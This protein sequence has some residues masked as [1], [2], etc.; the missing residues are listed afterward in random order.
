MRP[1][2]SPSLY[3]PPVRI[4]VADN[5][6]AIENFTSA[7]TYPT[8]LVP[9]E[10]GPG[11]FAWLAKEQD[12][13]GLF[14]LIYRTENHVIPLAPETDSMTF[15]IFE[16]GTE[17][18]LGTH[19]IEGRGGLNSWYR[20]NVGHAPDEELDGPRPILEL[21]DNVAAHLLLRHFE[22]KRTN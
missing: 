5:V 13:P 17:K 1:R 22:Q 9:C 7:S 21:I 6:M 18:P 12:A 14:G 16:A 4:G 2:I 8:T 10:T 15:T 20:S 19:I 3:V 11:R